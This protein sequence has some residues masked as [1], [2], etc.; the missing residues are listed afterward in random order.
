MK[1]R[2]FIRTLFS[3]PLINVVKTD[4]DVKSKEFFEK[5]KEV[6]K[7]NFDVTS[8]CIASTISYFK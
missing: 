2:N 1:R 5:P 6:I 3:L 4:L 7:S 8:S